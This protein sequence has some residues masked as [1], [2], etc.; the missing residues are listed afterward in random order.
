MPTFRNGWLHNFQSQGSIRWHQ[1]HGEAGDV[2][3]KAHQEM[4]EIKQLLSTFSLK[5]QFNCDETALFWKQT[6]ARSF[7]ARQIPGRKREKAC[8]S[9]LFCCNADGSEKLAPWFIGTAKNPHAFR[10][11]GIKIQNPDIIWRSN[12]KAWITSQIFIE[13]LRWFDGQMSG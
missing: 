2:S 13:F 4:F 5:D 9:A 3:M 12:R 11:A 10:A 8:I 6:P 1:Q 7:S